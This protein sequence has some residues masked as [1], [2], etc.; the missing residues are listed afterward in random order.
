MSMNETISTPEQACVWTR[1][2]PAIA[3]ASLLLASP[4]ADALPTLTVAELAKI[5]SSQTSSEEPDGCS[6]YTQGFVDGA[7]ATDPRVAVRITEE[8]EERESFTDRAFRTRL[9]QRLD[10]LGPS[11]LAG[12][13]I[14]QPI[15]AQALSALVKTELA[16]V[17][18]RATDTDPAREL[19]YRVLTRE[20]PCDT[21]DD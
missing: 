21:D 5:C 1:G 13:C 10:R 8:I 3:A 2:L 14:G 18:N 19:I 12:F 17:R 11:Y 20:F 16:L 15:S 7:I 6:L 4:A 9:G